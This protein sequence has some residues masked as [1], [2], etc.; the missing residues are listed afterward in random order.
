LSE[1][2][3]IITGQITDAELLAYYRTAHLYWSVS[4]HEG[5]GVPLVEAMWFDVPVVAYRSAAVP[6]TLGEAGLMFDRKDDLRAVAALAKLVT[7][8][9]E[10]LR[11]R[12]IA[13]GR[14]RR[15]AFTPA[16]VRRILDELLA[17][18]ES[19]AGQRRRVEVA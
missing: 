13:A 4:E 11:R 2:D 6:E 18:M 12:A 5:F 17:R 8:D 19:C 3:V 10:T 15:E 9:D 16:S 1:E 7:R 14:A